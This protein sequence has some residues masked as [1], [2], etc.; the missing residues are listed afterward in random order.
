MPSTSAAT[1][2]PSTSAAKKSGRHKSSDIWAHYDECPVDSKMA[3][4]KFCNSK[5]SAPCMVDE[6]DLTVNQPRQ[7][8]WLMF[9]LHLPL[10]KDIL[11]CWQGSFNDNGPC[12]HTL[13]LIM[14]FDFLYVVGKA[15]WS[16][17]ST[18]VITWRAT[19]R[20]LVHVFPPTV[21]IG[22]YA[23]RVWM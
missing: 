20:A 23:A 16:T 13:I 14:W 19:F 3:I 18:L 10:Y 5:V 17:L 22:R 12:Q 21:K 11:W 4:C 6:A 7:Q 8:L 9:D 2:T 1:A 15:D